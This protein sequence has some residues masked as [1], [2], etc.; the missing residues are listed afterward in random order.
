MDGSLASES[1]LDVIDDRE[2]YSLF[3]KKIN[4]MT[5]NQ[6][7]FYASGEE[8]IA[9]LSRR[10]C[11]LDYPEDDENLSVKD[12]VYKQSVDKVVMVGRS[13]RCPKKSCNKIHWGIASGVVVHPDGVVATNYHVVNASGNTVG[14]AVMTRDKRMY[15]VREVLAA[16]EETDVALLKLEGAESLPFAYLA[17]D[18][19]VGN[20]V[21][22]ISHPNRKLYMLTKG[23]VSRYYYRKPGVTFMNITAD[24]AK[25]SSGGPLFNQR[26]QLIGLVSSTTSLSSKSVRLNHVD[27]VRKDDDSQ[28]SEVN[29][30]KKTMIQQGHQMTL[31]NCV[32][33]SAIRSLIKNDVV[34]QTRN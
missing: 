3:G 9:Q 20:P 12:N 15:P 34:G 2:L 25:G 24:Y 16:N 30:R 27:P 5:R 4:E 11:Y 22:V 19:P 23:Y 18:E 17:A 1:V 6:R 10:S 28:P 31:K 13:Y 29:K 32:P 8:L 33:V 26:G 7:G 14:M 21:T